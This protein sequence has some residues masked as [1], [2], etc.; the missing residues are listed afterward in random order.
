MAFS[1]V[2]TKLLAESLHFS[3]SV[4]IVILKVFS[5]VALEAWDYMDVDMRD[6]LS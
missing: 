1:S 5:S 2:Q 6:F 3:V 4:F